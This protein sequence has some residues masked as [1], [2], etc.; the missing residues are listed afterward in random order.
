MYNNG[1]IYR[2]IK[3]ALDDNQLYSV[4]SKLGDGSTDTYETD[5]EMVYGDDCH[6][7]ATVSH[8]H[9]HYPWQ[10]GDDKV[11]TTKFKIKVEMIK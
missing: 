8:K 10:P 11:D 7:V 9:E 2:I 6:L 1:D 3:E 4:D 5:T